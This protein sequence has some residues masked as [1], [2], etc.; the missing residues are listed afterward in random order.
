MAINFKTVRLRYGPASGGTL[1]EFE[2]ASFTGKV[3]SA[4]L[5]V[6]GWDMEF[7]NG[8]HHVCRQRIDIRHEEMEILDNRV[9]FSVDFLLRDNTGPVDDPF[10]GY[11]DVLVIADVDTG[12]ITNP[13]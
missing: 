10:K 13:N 5:A 9:K 2:T 1:N 7:T 6:G 8:D 4:A 11:V 3:R 12:G